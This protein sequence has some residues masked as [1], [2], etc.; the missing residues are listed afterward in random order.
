MDY[1][2]TEMRLKDAIKSLTGLDPWE[3]VSDDRYTLI[4]GHLKPLEIGYDKN[5]K[6]L[7]ED[8]MRKGALIT[9][10]KTLAEMAMDEVSFSGWLFETTLKKDQINRDYSPM[11]GHF[12]SY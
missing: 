9:M 8:A 1:Q 11:S 10:L 12:D 3:R 7:S 6:L 4:L 2:L 5:R